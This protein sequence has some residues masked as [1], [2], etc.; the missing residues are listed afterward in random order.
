MTQNRNERTTDML[1][2][3]GQE[4][5]A[6]INLIISLST[7]YNTAYEINDLIMMLL[8]ASSCDTSVGW[9]APQNR[10][11]RDYNYSIVESNDK[12]R[13]PSDEWRNS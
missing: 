2:I 3:I 7:R 8:K 4:I 12:N 10:T 6:A 13:I 11:M 9:I 5:T 1:L